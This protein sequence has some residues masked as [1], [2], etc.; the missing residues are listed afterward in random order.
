MA[1]TTYSQTLTQVGA[2]DA[3]R[4]RLRTLGISP[5]RQLELR[6]DKGNLIIRS[7]NLK[8]IIESA[9]GRAETSLRSDRDLICILH[10]HERGQFELITER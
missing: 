4:H 2:Q 7:F 10:S 5:S 8:D 9:S 6:D 1:N 3:V